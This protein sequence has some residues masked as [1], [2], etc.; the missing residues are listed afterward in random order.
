MGEYGLTINQEKIREFDLN[1]DT[2]VQ[3][4]GLNLSYKDGKHRITISKSFILKTLD[5]I[6]DAYNLKKNI[7]ENYLLLKKEDYW[8]RYFNNNE[9]TRDEFIRN[10]DLIHAK[11]NDQKKKLPYVKNIVKSRVAYIKYNS[12]VSYKRFLKKHEN[13]FNVRWGEIWL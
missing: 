12:E 13:K 1:K 7:N 3:F 5:I 4:L 6:S 8:N 2:S 11:Y 9:I 10:L